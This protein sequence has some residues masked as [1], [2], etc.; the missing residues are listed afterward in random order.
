MSDEQL[1]LGPAR[2]LD[3]KIDPD[4]ALRKPTNLFGDDITDMLRDAR[5]LVDSVMV[6]GGKE[7]RRDA[8]TKVEGLLR[9]VDQLVEADRKEL[10]RLKR[11]LIE[12]QDQLERR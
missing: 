9:S 6:D 7:Q 11:Q 10:R 1:E 4:K 3:R 8:R 2:R 12:V 5:M